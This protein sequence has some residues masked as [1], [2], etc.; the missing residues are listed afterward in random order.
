MAVTFSYCY[1]H[2]I[3]T[4]VNPAITRRENLVERDWPVDL[5]KDVNSRLEQ[6]LYGL[7]IA[8]CFRIIGVLYMAQLA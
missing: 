1:Y 6:Y 5:R 7:W 2:E 4:F 3:H 8:L